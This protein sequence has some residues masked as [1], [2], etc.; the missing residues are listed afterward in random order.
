MTGVD[1]FNAMTT[2]PRSYSGW[3]ALADVLRDGKW[4]SQI[5]LA[6]HMASVTD[7]QVATARGLLRQAK[8]ARYLK[9]RKVK[10]RRLY[11]VTDEGRRQRPELRV[12]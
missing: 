2:F 12:R 11:S 5:D 10:G 6:N 8:L 7:M 4:H 9:G 3:L 1:D